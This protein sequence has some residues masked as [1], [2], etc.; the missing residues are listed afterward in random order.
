MLVGR[1]WELIGYL[2]VSKDI[3]VSEHSARAGA[4]PELFGSREPI[5]ATCFTEVVT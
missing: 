5:V 1:I 4:V 2:P 3:R